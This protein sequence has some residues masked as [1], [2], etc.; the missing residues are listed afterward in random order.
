MSGASR[1]ASCWS[2]CCAVAAGGDDGGAPGG[3]SGGGTMTVWICTVPEFLFLFR[4]S[5]GP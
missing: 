5:G 1:E 2:S 3:P 4:R